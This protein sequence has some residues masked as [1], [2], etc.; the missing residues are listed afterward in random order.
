[1]RRLIL[2]SLSPRRADL[3][4]GAGY[5]IEVRPSRVQE[6][7]S[8]QLSPRELT[9]FN[10][11]LKA[12][13]IADEHPEAVVLGAD[14]VV[15]C[16][17]KVFGKPADLHSA[18]AMLGEL[19]GKTHLVVTGYC[20][21][22]RACA[23]AKGDAEF[24]YVTLKPLTPQQISEYH[25]LVDPLD[26]AGAYAA[27]SFPELVIDGVDG[28]FDNVLGLPVA[29]VGRALAEFEVFPVDHKE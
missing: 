20:L 16:G 7:V 8:S 14:T 17:P 29:S 24:S 25:A 27:Q 23:K 11:R 3:L 21:I 10:A 5:R 4:R 13:R 2:A 6:S 22:C 19:A 18:A 28:P 12:R 26:K 1:M 9:L 15:A